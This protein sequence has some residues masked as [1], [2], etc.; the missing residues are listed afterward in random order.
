MEIYTCWNCG[1]CVTED[2]KIH[3]RAFCDEC[4]KNYQE[5][6]EA[7]MSTYLKMKMEIM[8]NRAI[9]CME[10]QEKVDINQY[11][12]ECQYVKDIAFKDFNK[13]QSSNEMMAAIE[14]LKCRVKTKMQYKIL[15][16]RVDFY[17]PDLKV[18]LEIDGRLHDFKVKKD[19]DRD[20]A[21]LAELNSNDKGWE[22][23]R[24]PTGYLEM[25]IKQLVP[26]IKA[27]KKEKQRLRRL[28][29]GFIP[30]SFNRSSAYQNKKIAK[31]TKDNSL[32]ELDNLLEAT[33]PKEL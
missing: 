5:E 27:V 15:K 16:Y 23:V 10:R 2:N 13:F 18:V 8:W 25:N 11:F 20:I 19:S 21:I 1:N 6:Y 12:D 17:L 4:R 32:S 30:V 33:A 31:L 29:G 7:Y 26:A 3:T 22:V 14:L 28:N 9:R 24:I